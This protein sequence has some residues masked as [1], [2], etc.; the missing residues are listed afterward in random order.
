MINLNELCHFLV[1]AKRSTYASGDESIKIKEKDG[2][3]TLVFE[4]GDFK[5][6]DNYFGGE[7]YGGREVV[8]YQG[9]P[10]YMMVYYGFVAKDTKDINNIYS[11]LQK[12]LSL[13]T[14]EYP[15]RGPTEFIEGEYKYSNEYSGEVDNFFGQEFIKHNGKIIYEARYIGGLIDQARE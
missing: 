7:P 2:S 10:V 1:K 13:I 6:H 3:T 8:F 5:Y 15:Y 14:E 11:V 9:I 4:N 12:A